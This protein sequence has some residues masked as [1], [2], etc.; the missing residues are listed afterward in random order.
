MSETE[1]DRKQQFAATSAFLYHSLLAGADP[2]PR[3]M[4]IRG[5]YLRRQRHDVVAGI[6]K[7]PQYVATGQSDRIIEFSRRAPIANSANP[8]RQA[9][10]AYNLLLCRLSR[11]MSPC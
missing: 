8:R 10:A 9:T 2:A 11:P 3:Q 1:Y 6:K 5:V 4:I 7:C